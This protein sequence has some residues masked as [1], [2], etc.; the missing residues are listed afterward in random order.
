MEHEQERNVI[1]V[2]PPPAGM[3]APPSITIKD[4]T[5]PETTPATM[6]KMLT[7]TMAATPSARGGGLKT[8]NGTKLLEKHPSFAS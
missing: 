8:R 7:A 5:E 2:T 6:S 1:T 3:S 4:V